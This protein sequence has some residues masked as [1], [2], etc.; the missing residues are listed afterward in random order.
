MLRHCITFLRTRGL[1]LFLPLD[2]HIYFH[3]ITGF[4]IF[5]YSILHTL[6]HLLNF[7][8]YYE[9]SLVKH[10]SFIFNRSIFFLSFRP[11]LGTVIIYDPNLNYEGFTVSEWLFTTDPELFGLIAGFANPTGVML[12]IILLV[13]F[14][15]SQPFVRRGGCFEVCICIYKKRCRYVC[16]LY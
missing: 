6:M 12:I 1:S 15:C 10:W 9:M 16:C 2:Q 11:Y 3:K 8:E 7:S 4:F 14:I 13:M 5:G